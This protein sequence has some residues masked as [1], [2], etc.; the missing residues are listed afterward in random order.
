MNAEYRAEVIDLS[1]SDFNEVLKLVSLLSDEFMPL[2]IELAFR[3]GDT[4]ASYL[5]DIS[6]IIPSLK[7]VLV[8]RERRLVQGVQPPPPYT[9]HL[10][11]PSYVI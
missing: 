6:C 5:K 1:G 4:R 3:S 9:P 8:N 10:P 11:P 2:A 7:K